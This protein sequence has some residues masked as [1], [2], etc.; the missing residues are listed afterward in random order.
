MN[1]SFL[2]SKK[3]AVTIVP[4]TIES[5]LNL[6]EAIHIP[7]EVIAKIFIEKLITNVI[8]IKNITELEEKIGIHCFK[9]I[10]DQMNPVLS[11]TFPPIDRDDTCIQG[12]TEEKIN[13]WEVVSEPSPPTGDRC[14]PSQVKTT[15]MI[16]Y[17]PAVRPD[18]SDIGIEKGKKNYLYDYTSS[19][20][21]VREGDGNE[22]SAIPT[23]ESKGKSKKNVIIELPSFT[24]INENE[25]ER[26]E[27]SNADNL[28]KE[29]ELFIIRK[30]KERNEQIQREIESK[31]QVKVELK[32]K[33]EFDF[34]KYAFDFEGN[35]YTKKVFKAKPTFSHEF[36]LTHTEVTRPKSK[37]SQRKSIFSMRDSIKRKT[38][39]FVMPEEIITNP[40]VSYETMRKDVDQLN[41]ERVPPSGS[42]F[43]I[44]YP[45]VGVRIT[46]NKKIKGGSKN[47]SKYFSK[48]STEE[49]KK[50]L[51]EFIPKINSSV[52]HNKIGSVTMTSPPSFRENDNDTEE[53]KIENPLLVSNIKR[54][55]EQNKI[56]SI[57]GGTHQRYQSSMFTSISGSKG[58]QSHRRFLSFTNISSSSMT[59]SNIKMN[60]KAATSAS[61]LK[62][63][64]D[65][66]QNISTI[67][68]NLSQQPSNKIKIFN[69]RYKLGLPGNESEGIV[70]INK[71]NTNIL[72]SKNW[73]KK[74]ISSQAQINNTLPSKPSN[75]SVLRE[76]GLNIVN[77]KLPRSRKFN[78]KN[79]YNNTGVSL[80]K[81]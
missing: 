50:I 38:K 67:E 34:D 55:D 76:L 71:F 56:L 10:K 2:M 11:L 5:D 15:F 32:P 62:M 35:I 77:Q 4:K 49:Y 3:F 53:Q 68:E 16:D 70:E 63:A 19:L 61:S 66:L 31:K 47:F 17:T 1:N 51:N 46:E 45:E 14:A 74:N 12:Q 33:K 21:M 57:E 37:V 64:L 69:S 39:K 23:E 48:T 22:A 20:G 59:E 30:A 60:P 44:I 78:H 80:F 79:L 72:K 26:R 40:Y 43:D 24:I 9:F 73:G 28:R 13:T 29:R 65:S 58:F 75:N 18:Y 8:R 81:I 41:G 36:Y 6:I 42:N 27:I 52:M 54:D 25:S 7:S